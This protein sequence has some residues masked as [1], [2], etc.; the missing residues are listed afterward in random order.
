[1]SLKARTTLYSLT[2]AFAL[3]GSIFG[4]I[5]SFM[6]GFSPYLIIF[7]KISGS[8]ATVT[9]I[10]TSVL[11][12]YQNRAYSTHWLTR[13]SVHFYSFVVFAIIWL[14]LGI[15]LSTQVSRECDFKTA[16]DGLAYS[17]CGLSATASVL[18]FLISLMSIPTA[19]LIYVTAWESGAGLEVNVAQADTPDDKV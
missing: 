1:M 2:L 10:W 13:S 12:S 6:D 19:L 3:C 8:V 18:A 4:Y 15:M 14:G 17:W 7:G 11:L 5:S 16:S 9:W